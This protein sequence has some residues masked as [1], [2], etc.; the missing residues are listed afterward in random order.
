[1]RSKSLIERRRRRRFGRQHARPRLPVIF[2]IFYMNGCMQTDFMID[3]TKAAQT[4]IILMNP[5]PG[6]LY[7]WGPR[8][9]GSQTNRPPLCQGGF[10]T[11][12]PMVAHRSL[13]TTLATAY[14]PVRQKTNFSTKAA[15]RSCTFCRFS[16]RNKH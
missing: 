16:S 9:G 6:P 3:R 15:V 5:G 12:R 11:S 8:L 4:V 7:L 14:G 1:M 13:G 2:F 10:S